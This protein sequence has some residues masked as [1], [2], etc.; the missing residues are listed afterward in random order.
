[1]S[2]N[3]ALRTALANYLNR[4]YIVGQQ[5]PVHPDDIDKVDVRWDSGDRNDPTYPSDNVAP[6]F[7]VRVHLKPHQDRQLT[8]DIDVEFVFSALLNMV[9]E[10]NL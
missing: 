2:Y 10:T 9:L 5:Y 3:D 4:H 1:M 7:E 6:T 8:A